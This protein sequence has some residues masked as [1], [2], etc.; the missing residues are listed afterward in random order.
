MDPRPASPRL[1]RGMALACLFF[2]VWRAGG[3]LTMHA[4]RLSSP[5]GTQLDA[6]RWS[7]DRRIQRTIAALEREIGR[8]PGYLG[9]MYA[10][11]AALPE[12]AVVWVYANPKDARRR[13]IMRLKYLLFPRQARPFVGT[14][15]AELG[16]AGGSYLL[17]F[18]S[19]PVDSASLG[20]RSVHAGPDWTLW[21]R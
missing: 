5:L 15:R 12:T 20:L 18:A 11:I 8:E 7:E 3:A 1:A 4:E 19:E 16:D 13:A 10:A 9:E 21:S 14:P 17:T 2:L 6:L